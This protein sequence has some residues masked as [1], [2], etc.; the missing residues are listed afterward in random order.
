MTEQAWADH[1][2]DF[3][4]TRL[5]PEMGYAG[6]SCGYRCPNCGTTCEVAFIAPR[7]E[8][9]PHTPCGVTH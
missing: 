7:W 6:V 1:Q 2:Y 3:D 4:T 9:I 8:H 5:Y